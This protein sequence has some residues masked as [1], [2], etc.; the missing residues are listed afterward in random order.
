MVLSQPT[1]YHMCLILAIVSVS[2]DVRIGNGLCMLIT[3]TVL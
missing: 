1:M 3:W 2:Q